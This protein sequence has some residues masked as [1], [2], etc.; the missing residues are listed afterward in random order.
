[1]QTPVNFMMVC[2]RLLGEMRDER[3]SDSTE[4]YA[5][6]HNRKW[7]NAKKKEIVPP[8]NM[9]IY[10]YREG[11]VYTNIHTSLWL[12]TSRSVFCGFF[13]KLNKIRP[14]L[15]HFEEKQSTV[16]RMKRR[17][18]DD[19]YHSVVRYGQYFWLIGLHEERVQFSGLKY[20]IENIC[21]NKIDNDGSRQTELAAIA[22]VA[23]E[24]IKAH[25]IHK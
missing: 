18:S 17:F 24:W 1:M 4:L 7:H 15:F 22:S 25:S 21:V 5:A 10:V 6:A 16:L 19:T 3:T 11:D 23:S 14:N 12:T 20:S 2:S 13:S 9:Y 8:M